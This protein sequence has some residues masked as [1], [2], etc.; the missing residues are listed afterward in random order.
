LPTSD[1][2]APAFADVA[3]PR[4]L[5]FLR[6]YPSPGCARR[7]TEAQ[8]QRFLVALQPDV[9]FTL[10][11]RGGTR[12][13]KAATDRIPIVFEAVTDPVEAGLVAGQGRLGGNLT[14]S[15]IFRLD[16]KRMHLLVE[17]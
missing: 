3:S 6:R 9:I 12:A 16:S 10:A 4:G 8:L 13:A 17:Q 15:A 14:G 2:R 7:L 5:A 11:G 1:G